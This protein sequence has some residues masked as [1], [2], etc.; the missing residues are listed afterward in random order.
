MTT[1]VAGGAGLV[2]VHLIDEDDRKRPGEADEGAVAMDTRT[3][4]RT[5]TATT[6]AAVR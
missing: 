6:E 1:A 5:C 3:R 2:V 4:T